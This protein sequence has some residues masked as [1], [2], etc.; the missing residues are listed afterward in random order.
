MFKTRWRH[1]W[2]GEL[3]AGA[4]QESE[5]EQGEG[6]RFRREAARGGETEAGLE[7]RRHDRRV[8]ER[9]RDRLHATGH[10]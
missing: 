10:L 7:K 9:A 8:T 4:Q 5:P 6:Q 2:R 1:A 3:D